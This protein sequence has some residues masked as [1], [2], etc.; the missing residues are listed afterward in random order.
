MVR[1]LTIEKLQMKIAPRFVGKC[2]EKLPGQTEA[3]RGGHI[4]ILLLERHLAHRLVIQAAV[5][6]IGPPAKIDHAT[7]QAFIHWQI[8]LSGKGVARI[9]TGAVAAKTGLIA[10]SFQERLTQR[11]TAILHRMMGIDLDISLAVKLKVHQR[12]LGKEGERVVEER[13]PRLHGRFARPIQIQLQA[14]IGLFSRSFNS[15]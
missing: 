5:D 8:S 4:L 1:L 2:L 12:V 9:K 7:D 3:E 14:D 11:Q 10:E 13:Y 15:S 6:Q